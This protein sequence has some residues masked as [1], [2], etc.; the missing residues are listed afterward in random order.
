M[1]SET[2]MLFA[3]QLSRLVLLFRKRPITRDQ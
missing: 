2:P 3:E 1:F